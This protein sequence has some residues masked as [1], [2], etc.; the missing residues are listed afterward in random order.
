M[1]FDYG[2]VEWKKARAR[3]LKRANYACEQCRADV[4]GRGRSRVD[5]RR[6]VKERPDLALEP[7]NLRVLCPTCDNRRHAEKGGADPM[8]GC[9][10]QGLPTSPSH[11]WN[12][13]P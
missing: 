13:R 11:P 5:H 4:R 8:R 9:D 6:T 1:P 12:R 7:T 10:A 2:S 3:A